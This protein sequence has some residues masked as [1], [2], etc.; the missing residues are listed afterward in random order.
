MS[1]DRLRERLRAI[2]AERTRREEP[3]RNHLGAGDALDWLAK[4]KS[5]IPVS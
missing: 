3:V 4:H 2:E 1:D 5:E